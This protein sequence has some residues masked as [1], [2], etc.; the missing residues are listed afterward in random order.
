MPTAVS[1]ADESA[2]RV[3]EDPKGRLLIADDIP[4]NRELLEAYLAAAG[5]EIE[6][7]VDGDDTLAK[8]AAFRPDVVLLDIMMPK[9]S[10]YEVCRKLKDDPE[11]QSISILMVTALDEAGD[12]EKAVAA[13]ADDFLSK[14]VNRVELATRVRSL[15]R[16][17]HLADENQ[18]LLAY[19]AD[20]EAGA[21]SRS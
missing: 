6:F 16:V 3:P 13:G 1:P 7:A 19:I 9:R 12:I 5:H 18:R 14:P 20:V 10:G 17:R 8:V 2:G 11:T 15:L 4:Q 21:K